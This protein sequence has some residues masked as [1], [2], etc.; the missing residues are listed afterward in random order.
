MRAEGAV[1]RVRLFTHL[2]ARRHF[3]FACQSLKRLKTLREAH[4]DQLKDIQIKDP[5]VGC[6]FPGVF[7]LLYLY[8]KF[9]RMTQRFTHVIFA[10]RRSL[11]AHSNS[12]PQ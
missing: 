4:A 7:W 5:N 8:V 1:R 6:V 9:W 11:A 3:V 12:I 10:L 2:V